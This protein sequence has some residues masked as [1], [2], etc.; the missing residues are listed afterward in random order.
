MRFRLG[1][2]GVGVALALAGGLA[3][4]GDD[5]GN[6][7]AEST[8]TA[9]VVPS[10]PAEAVTDLCEATKSIAA[11]GEEASTILAPLL[12][13]DDSPEA[14]AALL[15]AL[16][17]LTP[18]IAK[19][20]EGYE[21]MAKVLPEGLADDARKVSEATRAFY[22]GVIASKTIQQAMDAIQSGS[23]PATR[24][25]ESSARLEATVKKTCNLS[26]YG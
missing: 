25:Q 22:D 10:I 9:Y 4:C 24:A 21:R 18:S 1:A 17:T 6:A 26:L 20:Q 15:T 5:G 14:D 16:P 7:T 8:T 2:A 3:A 13:Q 11:A 12:A 23:G 19:A